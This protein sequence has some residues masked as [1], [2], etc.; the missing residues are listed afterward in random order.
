MISKGFPLLYK[1]SYPMGLPGQSF[2]LD[3][4][5]RGENL[6]SVAMFTYY[7]KDDIQSIQEQRREREKKQQ[8][9][10]LNAIYPSYEALKAERAEKVPQIVFT[11]TN[12]QGNVVRKIMTAPKK[13]I[14]RMYWD[15]RYADTDPINLKTSAFITLGQTVVKLFEWLPEPIM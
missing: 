1:P 6:P 8:K 7:I 14:H 10:G 3:S 5:Y 12:A 4:Y 13:G 15:M 9:E 11:V 2:Q